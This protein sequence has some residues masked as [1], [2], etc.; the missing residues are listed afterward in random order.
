MNMTILFVYATWV[1]ACLCICS[2]TYQP[3][4]YADNKFSPCNHV[5]WTADITASMARM[6]SMSDSTTTT[7]CCQCF[8]VECVSFERR[9]CECFMGWYAKVWVRLRGCKWKDNCF[10]KYFPTVLIV[11]LYILCLSCDGNINNVK[12]MLCVEYGNR[13]YKLV[14]SVCVCVYSCA[15][16]TGETRTEREDNTLNLNGKTKNVVRKQQLVS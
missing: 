9:I 7:N 16:N 15:L 6:C 4:T 13:L 12:C 3:H 8:C 5:P 14:G 1:S 2:V 10:H 11:F